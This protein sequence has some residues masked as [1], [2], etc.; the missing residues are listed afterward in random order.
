MMVMVMVVM[1][2]VDNYVF[3]F[4]WLVIIYNQGERGVEQN[5]NYYYYYV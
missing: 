3:F 1:V 2:E 5:K 4:S